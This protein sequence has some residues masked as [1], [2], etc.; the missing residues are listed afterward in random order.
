MLL[1]TDFAHVF[2]LSPRSS[3]LFLPLVPFCVIYNGERETGDKKKKASIGRQ[4]E[5][6]HSVMLSAT[7]NALQVDS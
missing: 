1:P 5:R 7:H 4:S 2:S 6:S 3:P